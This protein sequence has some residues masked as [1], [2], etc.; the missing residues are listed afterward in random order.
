[1]QVIS[2]GGN[3]FVVEATHTYASV[4]NYVAFVDMS[5][6]A[7]SY[8][9]DIYANISVTDALTGIAPV[10]GLQATEDTDLSAPAASTV[11]ATFTA[12]VPSSP[13]DFSAIITWQNGNTSTGTVAYSMAGG[14]YT[15]SGDYT[16][17]E[18]GI[19]PLAVYVYDAS[20]DE[21]STKGTTITV[22]DAPL[23]P[24]PIPLEIDELGGG[25]CVQVAYF[26]DGDPAAVSSDFS[27]SMN[28]AS[29]TCEI[30]PADGGGFDVYASLSSPYTGSSSAVTVTITDDDDASQTVTDND[31]KFVG[32]SPVTFGDLSPQS[33]VTLEGGTSLNLQGATVS[34]ST[35]TVT[36]A[37]GAITNGTIAAS[38][39]DLENGSIGANLV[40]TSLD[41]AG[42]GYVAMTGANTIGGIIISGAGTLAVG[43]GA[44]GQ[45]PITFQDDGT[46]QALGDLA[47]RRHR[48]SLRRTTPPSGRPSTPTGLTF[49]RPWSAAWATWT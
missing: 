48:P 39:F 7:T 3:G 34:L 47:S 26:T 12:Q 1:M 2:T 32:G 21:L 36:V 23:T 25:A 17:L 11:V 40:A 27:A 9:F 43:P 19:Y 5:D 29:A 14:D 45:G 49:R 28:L 24:T 42:D 15:V 30:V 10:A 38:A 16:Y 18:P 35:G 41:I 4:G 13:N 44:V 33:D 20:G 31:L 8:L 22:N 46:L 6:S 37:D